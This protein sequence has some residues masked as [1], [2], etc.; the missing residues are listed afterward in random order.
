MEKA[1]LNKEEED[2]WDAL[3]NRI[4]EVIYMFGSLIF[5]LPLLFIGIGY[6]VRAGLIAGGTKTLDIFKSWE[7]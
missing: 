4:T 5:F 1:E 6:G 3:A 7:K 2:R